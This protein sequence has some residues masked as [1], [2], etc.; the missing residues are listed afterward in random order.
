MFPI[1][2]EIKFKFQNAISKAPQSLG[3]PNLLYCLL[4]A[5]H[6][7]LLLASEALLRAN[8]YAQS[9]LF[10][11]LRTSLLVTSAGIPYQIPLL[12]TLKEF[13]LFLCSTYSIHMY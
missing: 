8:P 3:L 12:N 6:W 5:T 11:I 1:V 9:T 10:H 2:L 4:S 7:G 13:P